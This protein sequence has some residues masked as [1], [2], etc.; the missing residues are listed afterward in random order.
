MGTGGTVETLLIQDTCRC[1][2]RNRFG[3]DATVLRYDNTLS[4]K[5]SEHQE[6]ECN[7]TVWALVFGKLHDNDQLVEQMGT[8]NVGLT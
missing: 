1:R 6:S 7:V 3:L 4:N 2:C 5:N 8:P